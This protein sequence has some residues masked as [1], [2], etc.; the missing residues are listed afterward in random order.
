MRSKTKYKLTMYK[1]VLEIVS[2]NATS[3]EGIPAFVD[4]VEKFREKVSF[5]EDKEQVQRLSTVGVVAARDTLRNSSANQL[6]R[7][8]GALSALGKAN[9]DDIL[10]LQMK[11]SP[12]TLRRSTRS[13]YLSVISSI[14][15]CAAQHVEELLNYG[16]TAQEVLDLYDLKVQL[17]NSSIRPRAAMIDRKGSTVM[18][19]KLEKE[20]DDL[21]KNELDEMMKIINVT[22]ND[23]YRDYKAARS[24]I[25]YGSGKSSHSN[26]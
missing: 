3:W 12:S 24:I 10:H 11:I 13:E 8:S 5:L 23:F 17:M 18:I 1:T 20:I 6:M 2:V 14:V 15:N 16:I 7:I 25:N 4:T 26:E 9:G 19:A 21:L 22:N